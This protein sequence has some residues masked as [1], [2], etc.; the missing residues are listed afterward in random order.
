M[1]LGL[2]LGLRLGLGLGLENVGVG[3]K[4]WEK[5]G[6]WWNW[7]SR[8]LGLESV[9]GTVGVGTIVAIRVG[10]SIRVSI[11]LGKNWGLGGCHHI[12][13]S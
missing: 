8:E 9:S 1:G 5:L 6:L 11:R 3:I 2:E 10:V 12:F 4:G 7:G 13:S